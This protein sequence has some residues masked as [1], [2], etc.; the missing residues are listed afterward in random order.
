[1]D[2][3]RQNP[4]PTP[5]PSEDARQRGGADIPE[6]M[7]PPQKKTDSKVHYLRNIVTLLIGI[8]IAA[9]AYLGFVGEGFLFYAYPLTFLI[10]LF[11]IVPAVFGLILGPGETSTYVIP[12]PKNRQPIDPSLGRGGAAEQVLAYHDSKTQPRVNS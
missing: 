1:M 10:S 3:P 12:R 4:Q 7:A 2:A 9:L 8:G 6:T 11:F 5:A